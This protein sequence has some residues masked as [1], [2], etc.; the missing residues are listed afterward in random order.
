MLKTRQ[1]NRQKLRRHLP[2]LRN[3]DDSQL[4]RRQFS[5]LGE[6]Y[7][8]RLKFKQNN[9]DSQKKQ[10]QLY[11]EE[12]IKAMKIEL[13]YE[14]E[15]NRRLKKNMKELLQVAQNQANIIRELKNQPGETETSLELN[16]VVA[17]HQKEIEKKNQHISLAIRDKN[18]MYNRWCGEKEA[19]AKTISKVDE[20]MEVN[21]RLQREITEIKIMF[22]D[23]L[24][25][26]IKTN[27]ANKEL[28]EINTFIRHKPKIA[29]L[30]NI[31][32]MEKIKEF[33]MLWLYVKKDLQG[34]ASV[35]SE[36]TPLIETNENIQSG[37]EISVAFKHQT[38]VVRGCIID[39]AKAQRQLHKAT[40]FEDQT[41][42]FFIKLV[43]EKILE[44]HKLKKELKQK[45]RLCK[46]ATKRLKLWINNMCHPARVSP[47][48]TEEPPALYPEDWEPPDLDDNII[49]SVQVFKEDI[50]SCIDD[51]RSPH[52]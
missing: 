34:C 30:S 4:L 36:H 42:R 8:E 13:Q 14:N 22:N 52:I 15:G 1:R 26:L 35:I 16:K 10:A 7:E 25:K 2:Q 27:Q 50:L 51:N 46:K 31:N 41:R 45:N 44:V 19:H 17:R 3:K 9:F 29:E 47:E 49:L 38:D 21:E 11:H 6:H 28:I 32:P 48:V 43:N 39:L 12:Q 33:E 5:K 20:M 23:T 18:D 37:G 40:Q 24:E